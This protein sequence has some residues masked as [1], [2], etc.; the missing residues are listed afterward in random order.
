[1]QYKAGWLVGGESVQIIRM[2]PLKKIRFLTRMCI[3][4]TDYIR[5]KGIIGIEFLSSAEDEEKREDAQVKA[6]SNYHFNFTEWII[7]CG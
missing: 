2:Q 7:I 3:T 5:M 6:I 1:M 4:I